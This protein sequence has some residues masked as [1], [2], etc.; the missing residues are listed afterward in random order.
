MYDSSSRL[1]IFGKGILLFTFLV[2]AGLIYPTYQFFT[3]EEA[4]AITPDNF[5][6]SRFGTVDDLVLQ[7]LR[8]GISGNLIVNAVETQGA[9]R[10]ASILNLDPTTN[11]VDLILSNAATYQFVPQNK[12]AGVAIQYVES[13]AQ[14]TPV[15]YD[16]A[17]ETPEVL[18]IPDTHQARKFVPAPSGE[19]YAGDIYPT[20]VIGTEQEADIENWQVIVVNP[21]TGDAFTIFGAV[22]P[23]WLNEGEDVAYLREDGLYRFNVALQAEERMFADYTDLSAHA[24][25]AVAPGGSF[26]VLTMPTSNVLSVLQFTDARNGEVQEVGRKVSIDENFATPVFSP[27]GQY[28]AVVVNKDSDYNPDTGIYEDSVIAIY[29]PL[30]M[31]PLTVS[32]LE[33]VT[34]ADVSLSAWSNT[35]LKLISNNSNE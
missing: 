33:G 12:E 9:E 16:L 30:S 26:A 28:Y 6:Q 32:L 15:L 7:Q 10:S 34:Q 24:Q 4:V 13:L 35:S 23:Q 3:A 8:A 11:Q 19:W 27:G 2:A 20:A 1:Q 29:S 17:V 31:S 22:S 14:A 5:D 25:L 21:T 18:L